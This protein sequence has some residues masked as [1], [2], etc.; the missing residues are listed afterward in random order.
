MDEFYGREMPAPP[1]ARRALRLRPARAAVR[2]PRRG[3]RRRGERYAPRDLV[4]DRRRAVDRAAA[5]ARAAC[6]RVHRRRARRSAC[7][8]APW[9]RWSRPRARRR[10]PPVRARRRRPTVEVRGRRSPP[11]S[12]GS[13]ST[14]TRPRRR[15][16]WAAGADAGGIATGGYASGL[17]AALVLGPHRRRARRSGHEPVTPRASGSRRAVHASA[18]RRSCC[19]STRETL[20][21]RARRRARCCRGLDCPSGA[22][23]HEAFAAELE[24]R[25]PPRASAAEAVAGAGRRARRAMRAA[26]ATPLAAGLHPDA[27]LRR[28]PAGATGRA[29]GA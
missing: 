4:G 22:A 21:A 24:L 16:V 3:D 27:A 9:P 19:W 26:G 5:A 18:S 23:G 28:R 15:G 8:S 25:S 6:S 10:A 17:A 13:R 29:T 1:R 7:A 2:P 11:R 14:P 12:A 20:P